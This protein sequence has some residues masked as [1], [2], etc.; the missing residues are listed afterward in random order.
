MHYIS[1][2]RYPFFTIQVRWVARQ[3][4]PGIRDDD[5]A[6]P[7]WHA[8][9]GDKISLSS[10]AISNILKHD[11]SP[12]KARL[13]EHVKERQRYACGFPFWIQS[14]S[15]LAKLIAKGGEQCSHM[16]SCAS[17]CSYSDKKF[18]V[19]GR[20]RKYLEWWNPKF[21]YTS[22]EKIVYNKKGRW[23]I[24]ASGGILHHL[25]SMKWY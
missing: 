5:D 11:E 13:N 6:A 17:I 1:L 7:P 20:Q 22:Y 12:R 16:I 15:F 14:A 2:N 25:D 23:I 8:S 19:F 18:D 10:P 24:S 4:N 3:Q 21:D 9:M